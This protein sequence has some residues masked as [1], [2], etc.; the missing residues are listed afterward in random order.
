MAENTNIEWTDSTWNPT[1]GC[2]NISPGCKNCYAERFAERFRGVSGH[3]Y[4]AGFDIRTVPSKVD[5]PFSWKRPRRIFVNSM[6]DLFH[7]DIPVSYLRSVCDT[8]L[9]AHW[10]TYQILTKRADY[11]KDILLSDLFADVVH[12]AHIWWGVSVEDRR[13][14]NPR[15]EYLRRAMVRNSFLSVEPLLEDLGDLNL[16]GI[17]WV[18][19]GGESGPGARPCNTVWVRE[20]VA[21]CKAANVPVFVKQLGAHVIQNGERRI[22]RDKKGGDMDEWPHDLRVREFPA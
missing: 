4:E 2:D 15:I 14:G 9:E 18:I 12:A 22:K 17:G 1:R 10:H 6:S 13:Y 7:R 8:M 5:A 11:M 19:V 3:P 16:S 21:Q 20:I